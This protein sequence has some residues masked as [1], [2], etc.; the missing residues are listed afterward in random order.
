MERHRGR[1]VKK[2]GAGDDAG[3]GEL[4]R[5]SSGE[6]GAGQGIG[7]DHPDQ[8]GLADAARLNAHADTP[9]SLE[10]EAIAAMNGAPIDASLPSDP[11]Q[12]P[13]PAG[14]SPEEVLAGY[15]LVCDQLVD[16][17]CNALVPAWKVSPREVSKL[18]TACAKALL[19]WFPDQIIPPKYMALLAIVG[20]G[21]EI[22]QARRDPRTGRYLPG[23][24]PDQAPEQ[25]GPAAAAPAH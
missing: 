13:D 19:L 4:R 25:T 3:A 15:V 11:A 16:A 8:V 2:F 18:G 9:A 6:L 1:F 17:G 14:P 21:F 20:V 24:L 10:A 23:Q 22:A 7:T 5:G 12:M